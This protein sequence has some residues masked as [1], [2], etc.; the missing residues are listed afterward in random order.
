MR[1]TEGL[2]Y[3]RVSLSHELGNRKTNRCEIGSEC[4]TRVSSDHILSGSETSNNWRNEEQISVTPMPF[5]SVWLLFAQSES[6]SSS[7]SMSC[8]IA[9]LLLCWHRFQW[10]YIGVDANNI[11][12][13]VSERWSDRSLS[14]QRYN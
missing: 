13:D 8:V 6:H 3:P 5:L 9:C 1:L 7:S 2:I 12:S 14:A 11:G 4:W 10:D